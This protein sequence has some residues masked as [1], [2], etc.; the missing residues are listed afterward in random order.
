MSTFEVES[1]FFGESE[2][3][4]S[5]RIGEPVATAYSPGLQHRK[6][7][8][9]T[10]WLAARRV[11]K[12][13]PVSVQIT[14]LAAGGSAVNRNGRAREWLSSVTKC[15][16]GQVT[17]DGQND[18]AKERTRRQ[19]GELTLGE[20]TVRA[21]AEGLTTERAELQRHGLHTLYKMMATTSPDKLDSYKQ[22]LETRPPQDENGWVYSGLGRLHLGAY[23]STT[24]LEKADAARGAWFTGFLTLD[25]NFLTYFP[26]QD[27]ALHYPQHFRGRVSVHNLR[28][29]GVSRSG[30]DED[31]FT[32][33]THDHKVYV[34]TTLPDSADSTRKQKT[35]ATTE[36]TTDKC[37][38]WYTKLTDLLTYTN[39][40]TEMADIILEAGQDD[41]DKGKD[42][43]TILIDRYMEAPSPWSCRNI[44]PAP[45]TM[46]ERVMF[47]MNGIFNNAKNKTVCVPAVTFRRA[48]EVGYEADPHFGLLRA[49]NFDCS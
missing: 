26:S 14:C 40:K 7:R 22:H 6:Q 29:D 21:Q 36:T 15:G 37:T 25:L 33:T 5:G 9:G 43:K 42:E 24:E 45:P 23:D 17:K 34:I 35:D 28:V 47:Y 32:L 39:I 3:D 38:T 19:L 27:L 18:P 20:V 13:A 8:A 31:T 46:R 41:I 1:D 10:H 12:A 4:L 11:L 2:L 30:D 44:T 49:I 48:R 16:D